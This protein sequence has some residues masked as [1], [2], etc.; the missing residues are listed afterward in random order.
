M[1]EGYITI[2]SEMLLLSYYP[3]TDVTDVTRLLQ[4]ISI[5]G[6][7]IFFR[8]GASGTVCEQCPETVE[9]LFWQGEYMRCVPLAR[10]ASP[11]EIEFK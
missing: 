5:F 3:L 8:R 6:M 4:G 2:L 11:P 10:M 9:G 1:F 7:G